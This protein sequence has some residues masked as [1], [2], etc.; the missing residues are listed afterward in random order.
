MKAEIA[1][2]IQDN[3]PDFHQR[4]LESLSHLQLKKVLKRKNPYLFKAKNIN[5]AGELVQRI[6]DAH[7]SSQEE[8]IFGAFLENVAVHACSLAYG[9]IKSGIEGIDLEFSFRRRPLYRLGEV[10]PQLGQQQPD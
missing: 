4:R 6:L 8:T 5:T 2:H 10:R 3:I 1:K 7:L 9:G